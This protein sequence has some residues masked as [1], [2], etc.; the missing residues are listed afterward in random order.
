L[1]IDNLGQVFTRK[2]IVKTML[3]LRNNNGTILEP[4][5][6]N[7]A[8]INQIENCI[9]IELDK[10]ICPNNAI[11]MDFFNFNIS[12]KFDTIIGN[13]PYVKYKN[14]LP[15]TKNLLDKSFF[16]ERTNLYLFFIKKCIEHLNE[17]GELIFITPRD[18]L[19]NTSSI[20]LNNWILTQGSF[21]HFIDLGDANIWEDGSSPSVAYW[22]FQKGL[23]NTKT[24]FNNNLTNT[25]CINGQI[26]FSYNSYT[27][28]LSNLFFVKVGAVSGADHIF[29][30]SD[31]IDFVCSKTYKENKL[32]KMIYN[33]NH[34]YL[35]NYKSELINR[36]IKKFDETNWWEWGRKYYVSNSDRIYVNGKI[37]ASSPF[38]IHDCKVYDGSVLALFPKF[39]FDLN[40]AKNM[41]NE[42][43]W[44]DLGFVT[45]GRTIF[46]QKSL[47]NILL[48]NIFSTL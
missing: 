11:N 13:P 19:K 23:F 33:T 40:Q 24:L 16:D 5:C 9:G 4:S 25:Q 35:L 29:E 32:K 7:G 41:L 21:T 10:D 37:R 28:P 26:I 42:V 38:F 1:N 36:K 45:N 3:L 18:F 20:K 48:P 39:D 17:N 34:P 27:I 8:F 12:N 44:N 14:I 31:G 46:S 15:E 47:E 2:D 22:R 30:H 43:N 6:G